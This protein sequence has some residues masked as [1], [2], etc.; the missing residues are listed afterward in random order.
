M[1]SLFENPEKNLKVKLKDNPCRGIAIGEN[2]EG[3][4]IQLSWIMGRS[5]NSQNRVYTV[6]GETVNGERMFTEAADPKKVKD[7]SLIIYNAMDSNKIHTS[8]S[9]YGKFVVSNGAQTDTIIKKYNEPV[10]MVDGFKAGVY[11]HFCEPDEPIFTPRISAVQEAGNFVSCIAIQKADPV[12]KKFWSEM[13]EKYNLSPDKYMEQSKGD[14]DLAKTLYL[15]EMKD[16]TGLNPFAFPTVTELYEASSLS[17]G[18]GACVTTY[19]PGDSRNLPSFEGQPFVIPMEGDLE[20]IMQ[21]VWD[22]LE[23]QWRVALGGREIYSDGT[24]RY[25]EPINIHTK[26]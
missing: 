9:S 4:Q 3:N 8:L 1:K 19:A 12:A 23:P 10:S 20:D 15:T 2:D 25:A 22:H 6:E 21:N 5:E 13:K 14:K 17:N 16:L 11:S 26:K 18:K 24:S 7:P